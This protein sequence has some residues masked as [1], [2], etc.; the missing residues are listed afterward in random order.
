MKEIVLK[1][2]DKRGA[3]TVL[4]SVGGSAEAKCTEQ[5]LDFVGKGGFVNIFAGT[6]PE[7]PVRMSP[8]LLH[9][10]EIKVTGTFSHTPATYSKAI[11]LMCT[12]KVDFR[13]L[14]THVYPLDKI[15]QAFE[16]VLHKKEKAL[17]VVV[18]P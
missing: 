7:T 12:K 17:K 9:Y 16:T 14:I 13:P 5:A 1:E 4:V 18:R 8:N 6:Y 10:N 2:T 11:E 15:K 3:D